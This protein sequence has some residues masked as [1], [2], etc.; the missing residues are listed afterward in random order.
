MYH[1]CWVDPVYTQHCMQ[2]IRTR[3]R[4]QCVCVCVFTVQNVRRSPITN[5]PHYAQR[6]GAMAIWRYGDMALWRYGAGNT[7]LLIKCCQETCVGRRRA[8]RGIVY[9]TCVG[10]RYMHGMAL[11]LHRSEVRG[12]PGRPQGPRRA[13]GL[14]P[15][16]LLLRSSL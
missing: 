16:V 7:R 4:T 6:S 5:L 11:R 12:V 1:L 14:P 10:K 13:P 8:R 9:R 15:C 3:A 2:R